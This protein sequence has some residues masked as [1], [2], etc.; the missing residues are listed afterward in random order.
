MSKNINAASRLHTIL[1]QTVGMSTSAT[2]L[3][4]W[5]NVFQ[6]QGEANDA[7]KALIISERLR[8]LHQELEIARSQMGQANISENLYTAA[9]N[10]IEQAL[11]TLLLSTTWNNGAQYLKPETLVALEFCSEILPDEES[12]IESETLDEIRSMVQELESLLEKTNLPESL[13]T[14]ILHHIELINRALDQYPVIGA[15]ALREAARS[16]IGELIE[17]NEAVKANS[18]SEEVSQL[19]K[20]WTKLNNAADIAI[21]A[22][23][24]SQIGTKAWAY[25]EHIVN[26]IP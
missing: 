13:I 3:A 16:A 7:R 1:S 11:S 10:N 22:D 12:L 25:L 17:A 18:G 15:M 5:E 19:G 6:I 26:S 23:K 21:K 8:W 24:I 4:I 9:F 14:L 2:S 20:I